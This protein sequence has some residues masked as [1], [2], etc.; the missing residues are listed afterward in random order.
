MK[1]TTVK[2]WVQ[3][4]WILTMIKGFEPLSGRPFLYKDVSSSYIIG[5]LLKSEIGKTFRKE[6][7]NENNTEAFSIRLCLSI[8]SRLR[9]IAFKTET[10]LGYIPNNEYVIYFW[11]FFHEEPSSDVYIR[12]CELLSS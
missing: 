11:C 12:C 1:N 6:H 5:N 2:K 8:L 7:E 9:V 3:M 10:Q 4:E